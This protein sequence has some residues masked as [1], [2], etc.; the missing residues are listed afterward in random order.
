MLLFEERPLAKEF[1]LSAVEED[2]FKGSTFDEMLK[3]WVMALHSIG[4]H[5]TDWWR[6]S[7]QSSVSLHETAA[8][9]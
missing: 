2:F 9:G 1:L 6:G 8:N 7:G 5:C 3:N 4:M